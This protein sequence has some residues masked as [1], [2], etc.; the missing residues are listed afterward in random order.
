MSVFYSIQHLPLGTHVARVMPNTP[1]VVQEGGSVFA[2]GSYASDTD[3]KIINELFESVGRCWRMNEEYMDIVT[4]LS[5]CGPAFVSA[6]NVCNVCMMKGAPWVQC[7]Y[8]V[9]V[10]SAC[11]VGLPHACTYIHMY[12][13]MYCCI[14]MLLHVN[15]APAFD[16]SLPL[17]T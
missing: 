1:V 12:V 16:H 4:A 13:Q 6:H 11:T 5:G 15:C 10:W 9:N 17:H 14:C 8:D 2:T 3:V 7:V